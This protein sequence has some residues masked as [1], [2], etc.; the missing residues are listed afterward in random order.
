MKKISMFSAAVFAFLFIAMNAYS[1]PDTVAV[2]EC[3]PIKDKCLQRGDCT[4]EQK[5]ENDKKYDKCY[6]E[7]KEREKKKIKK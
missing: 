5:I 4:K 3:K 1:S 7:V 2:K 6:N